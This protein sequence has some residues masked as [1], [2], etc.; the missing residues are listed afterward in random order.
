MS[1]REWS[2]IKGQKFSANE[3][4]EASDFKELLNQFRLDPLVVFDMFYQETLSLAKRLVILEMS[5]IDKL[6]CL[7]KEETDNRLKKIIVSRMK[8]KINV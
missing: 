4:R 5:P 1:L 7:L 6:E 2:E 3:A 8:E